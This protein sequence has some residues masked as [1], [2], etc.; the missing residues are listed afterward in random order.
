M[1]IN[2][3]PTSRR[4]DQPYTQP[5]IVNGVVQTQ[6]YL[7][8]LTDITAKFSTLDDSNATQGGNDQAFASALELDQELRVLSSQTSRS[9]WEQDLSRVKPANLCQLFHYYI[10]LRV[11]LPFTMR[12]NS[13]DGNVYS[14]VTC[15]G[16]CEAVARRYQALRRM[17][18]SG[19]FL[20]RMMDLQAVST[21]HILW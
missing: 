14:R 19:I 8:R 7:K 9:W 4:L 6:I 11:H 1:V 2:K 5:L 17:L 16:A 20:S 21:L 10:V 13:G 18:P 3:P 15:M 12:Q